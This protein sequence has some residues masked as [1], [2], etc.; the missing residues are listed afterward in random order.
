LFVGSQTGDPAA[1]TAT[2]ANPA[3]FSAPGAVG[4]AAGQVVTLTGSLPGGFS[5]NTA[6]YVVNL[7]T[8][9]TGTFNLDT[10][11]SGPGI[12]STSAG[13][14]NILL[15]QVLLT[16]AWSSVALDTKANDLWGTFTTSNPSQS[17]GMFPGFYLATGVF[18][19]Q[20]SGGTGTVSAGITAQE[21]TGPV[22]TYGGQ[23]IKN[24]SASPFPKVTCA[25][26]VQFSV[27]GTYGGASNNYAGLSAWEDASAT[28]IV[29]RV[30]ATTY[31]QLTLEWVSLL[32]NPAPQGVLPPVP[33]NDAWPVPPV[34]GGAMT[35]QIVTESFLNKN[36]RD[37][38]SFLA[39]PP[40]CEAY[41]AA[42]ASLSSQ[43][44]LPAVGTT[45][46]LDTITSTVVAADNYSAF[47][48]S[49]HTWTCK[50][51]GI[52]TVTGQ[53]A[54]A[55]ASTS[56]AVAAGL[57]IQATGYNSGNAFTLWSGAQSAC[58]TGGQV[59]CALISRRLRFA[60]GDTVKL[61]AFQNNSG[62]ASAALSTGTWA[63]RL[64]TI[65]RAA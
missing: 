45:V 59:S 54:V 1:F 41:L 12:A 28:A 51:P 39:F 40:V 27:T 7:A 16:G 30:T 64:I 6:Y 36:I 29:P 60:F 13:S 17:F 26:L 23:R 15:S 50:R 3:V 21:G 65:W 48:V 18:S 14:G 47:S 52:Y 57:T 35:S 33:S 34:S 55:A 31:P 49:S 61:A 37:T 44:S 63:C 53:V 5:A 4:L 22:T 9:G 25:K 11:S 58:T 46:P 32:A 8:D 42:G 20:Y 38:I 19:P 2:H 56:V 43:S 24:V 62:G 10:S